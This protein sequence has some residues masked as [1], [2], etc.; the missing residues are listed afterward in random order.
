MVNEQIKINQIREAL[1]V[2]MKS[3][4][5]LGQIGL[6]EHQFEAFRKLVMDRFAETKRSLELGRCGE[7][8]RM[9]K[10]VVSMP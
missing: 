4:L 2:L 9:T 3:M 1:N 8:K 7:N 10:G 5:D 6:P